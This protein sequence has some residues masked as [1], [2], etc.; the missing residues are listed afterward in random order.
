M[1]WAYGTQFNSP[2]AGRSSGER[3][4]RYLQMR[5]FGKVNRKNYCDK[6]RGAGQGESQVGKVVICGRLEGWSA[7]KIPMMSPRG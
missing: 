4:T 6:A 5:G 7:T 3:Y 2:K 1:W